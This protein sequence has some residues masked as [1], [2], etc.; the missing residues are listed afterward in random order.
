MYI[1]T[2]VSTARTK[3]GHGYGQGSH[4][5]RS[6]LDQI[7]NLTPLFSWII[8]IGY[9]PGCKFLIDLVCHIIMPSIFTATLLWIDQ[10]P[11]SPQ[12]GQFLSGTEGL[13]WLA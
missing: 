11:D 9:S 8:L 1:D 2:T 13:I 10:I 3:V 12:G 7:V 5:I 6:A 4:M